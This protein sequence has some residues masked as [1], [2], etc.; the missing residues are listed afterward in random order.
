MSSFATLTWL[1]TTLLR[2]KLRHVREHS[3]LKIGVVALLGGGFWVFLF[4]AS[5]H[6]FTFLRMFFG[7]TTDLMA[8][9]FSLLFFALMVMLIFS[10][11]IIAYTSLYHSRETE[12]LFTMPVSA[13]D[14]FGYKFLESALF[15]SW[16]FLLL[17]LPPMLA[18]GLSVKAGPGFY[19]AIVAFFVGFVGIPASIGSAAAMLFAFVLSPKTRRTLLIALATAAAVLVVGACF[20]VAAWRF[21]G[22]IT[23]SWMGELLDKLRFSQNPLLPSFWIAEGLR[24]Y[25]EGSLSRGFFFLL[26]IGVNSVAGYALCDWLARTTY[27]EGWARAQ[28][29]KPK[30]HR[31]SAFGSRSTLLQTPSLLLLHKDWIT[32]RRDPVQWMQCA[33]MLGLLGLYFV[34][35]RNLSYH[36]AAAFWKNLTS[37]LNLAASCLVLAT[38]ITRF[39]YPLL[40]LEGRRFWILGLAPIGRQKILWGKFAFAAILS[41]AI[42][43]ILIVVSN[44][45]LGAT[46]LVLWLQVS[47]VAL[48]CFALSGLAVGMSAL[49]PDFREDNPSKIVSG[50]GGTLTLILSLIYVVAVIALEVMPI[51]YGLVRGTIGERA[52]HLWIR[53]AIVGVV[54]LSTVVGLLP[55]ALGIRAFRRMEF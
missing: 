15:S 25:A 11:A 8:L 16:A 12:H 1:R 20:Y 30:Q 14:V 6:S 37:F 55:M 31:R 2:N 53:S 17:G 41:T 34:N 33:I 50:F 52:F 38:L 18:Y 44:V 13:A 42:V 39:V 48:V 10:N 45:M 36:V 29:G 46:P 5:Y 9:F 43:E 51:H 32:F 4:L 54:G 24:R 27:A 19:P 3:L 21:T 47:T 49:Y 7:D 22:Q 26:V 35:L 40:S 23:Y 28:E